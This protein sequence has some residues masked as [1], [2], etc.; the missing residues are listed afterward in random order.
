MVQCG[1]R[2]SW[3]CATMDHPADSLM[4]AY[5]S[6]AELSEISS[7]NNQTQI[8]QHIDA[9]L[10]DTWMMNQNKN[11]QNLAAT[12]ATAQQNLTLWH[13]LLRASRGLLNPQKCV[14]F[15]FHWKFHPSRCISL[16][17]LMT[18]LTLLITNQHQSTP[19]SAT[20][21]PPTTNWCSLLPWDPIHYWWN[22]KCKLQMFWDHNLWYVNL[23]QKCPLTHHEVRVVYLQCYL[24]M[25]S[26]PLPVTSMSHKHLLHW[27]NL[28]AT[29]P[30]SRLVTRSRRSCTLTASLIG[31]ANHIT[32]TRIL[33]N[34][35]SNS[36]RLWLTPSWIVLAHPLMHGFSVCNTSPSFL[37]WRTL[38][39]SSAPPSLLLLVPL[40]ILVCFYTSI[41]GNLFI[42]GMGSPLFFRSSLRKVEDIL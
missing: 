31:R 42:L 25:V 36:W 21:S 14:W 15:L 34:A 13:D 16:V 24:P 7:P 41:F 20:H 27:P 35:G 12:C 9:F 29:V 32:S 30:K 2:Q 38:L 11:D 18:T 10:D 8:T 17:A 1:T 4:Q 33:L 40:M 19:I 37:T 23:L 39:N 28:S 22:Q 26:Y 5:Q 3:W 6:Q